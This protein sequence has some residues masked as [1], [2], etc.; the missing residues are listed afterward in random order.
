MGRGKYAYI[1]IKTHIAPTDITG[2][3]LGRNV[4]RYQLR[5]VCLFL[6]EK[7]PFVARGSKLHKV[8]GWIHDE[9]HQLCTGGDYDLN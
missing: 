9:R 2:T 5:V 4:A 8:V 7:E 6:G 1:R 3:D